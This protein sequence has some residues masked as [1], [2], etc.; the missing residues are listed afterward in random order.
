MSKK[1]TRLLKCNMYEDAEEL[2]YSTETEVVKTK[3]IEPTRPKRQTSSVSPSKEAPDRNKIFGEAISVKSVSCNCNK[4]GTHVNGV[5]INTIYSPASD[6]LTPFIS[7]ECVNCKHSGF[8]SVLAKALPVK[9][10]DKIYFN[11]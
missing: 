7:Y 10:F 5:L 6:M 1:S 3:H 4:C 2:L 8:R 11:S 9:D